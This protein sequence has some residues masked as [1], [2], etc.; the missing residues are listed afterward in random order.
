MNE[1]KRKQFFELLKLVEK[2][3]DNHLADEAQ[4]IPNIYNQGDVV[5][6][7]TLSAHKYVKFLGFDCAESALNLF[8][9][10]IPP[11][12]L[13]VALPVEDEKENVL[14]GL[15]KFGTKLTLNYVDTP[16]SLPEIVIEAHFGH[17]GVEES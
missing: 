4:Y 11:T 3:F 12:A 7:V 16:N 10:E 15:T 2:S 6:G 13:F 8:L 14:Q 5:D 17:R 9:E 1:T